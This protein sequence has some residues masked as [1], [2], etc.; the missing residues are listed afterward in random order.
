MARENHVVYRHRVQRW[1]LCVPEV[2][3]K[4]SVAPGVCT[5]TWGGFTA[6]EGLSC[7]AGYRGLDIVA[8]DVNTVSPP[9]D[10]SG[11]TAHL[12]AYM[13]YEM[14]LLIEEKAKPAP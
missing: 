5:P 9:H 11:M 1:H 6:R 7:C 3:S 2:V 14:L 13:T 12:A 4:P 10:V 8:L